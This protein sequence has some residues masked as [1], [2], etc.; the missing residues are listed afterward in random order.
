MELNLQIENSMDFERV[1]RELTMRVSGIKNTTHRMQAL[2]LISNLQK[3]VSELA[4]LELMSRRSEY[5]R[6]ENVRKAIAQ[7]NEEIKN[8]EEILFMEILTSC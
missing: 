7:I 3:M 4:K 5:S 2:R 8:V 1:D 6:G